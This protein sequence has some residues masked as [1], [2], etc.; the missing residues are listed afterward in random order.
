MSFKWDQITHE[1]SPFGIVGYIHIFFKN[2]TSTN[3]LL[4]GN[5]EVFFVVITKLWLLMNKKV[6]LMDLGP[7]CSPRP[8]FL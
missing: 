2:G 8:V 7:N 6:Y 5:T 1:L 3:S 4:Y